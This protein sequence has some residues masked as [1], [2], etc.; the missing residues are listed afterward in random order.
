MACS[1]FRSLNFRR[2]LTFHGDFSFVSW[3]F[4]LS[5]YHL[6]NWFETNFFDFWLKVKSSG[7]NLFV[8]LWGTITN[9]Q[10]FSKH[11]NL[12]SLLFIMISENCCCGYP[13]SIFFARRYANIIFSNKSTHF[14]RFDQCFFVYVTLNSFGNLYLLIDLWY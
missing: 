13:I 10:L 11:E 8:K 7:W 6:L 4:T 12:I 3:R 2:S 9:L 14:S 5:A 1:G